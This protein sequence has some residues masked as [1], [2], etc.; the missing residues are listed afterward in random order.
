MINQLLLTFISAMIGGFVGMIFSL[1]LP[2]LIFN[3]RIKIVGLDF[4]GHVVR[5]IVVNKG[6][7]AATDAVGRMTI[8]PIGQGD[9]IGTR[10]EIMKARKTASPDD[11]WRKTVNA[12]LRSED[13]QL[14]I[15]MEHTFWAA[16]GK[17]RLNI[18]PELPERLVIAY[19][20]GAWVDIPSEDTYVKRTRLKL[21]ESK[22]FYGEVVIGAANCRLS[23]PFYFQI[24]LGPNQIATVEPYKGKMPKK[25]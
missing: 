16:S 14:G 6:R 11:D 3:P 13:W 25:I 15:E 17:A 21:S 4:H 24:S 7:T 22:I 5:L 2:R 9:I 10:A 18:N 12:H 8:R 23:K 1:F 19:S 20:E